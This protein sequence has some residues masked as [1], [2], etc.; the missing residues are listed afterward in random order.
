[1]MDDGWIEI[2]DQ[3]IDQTD[4]RSADQPIRLLIEID[5]LS[6]MFLCVWYMTTYML[7]TAC[8]LMMM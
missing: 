8:I 3:P 7:L 4:Q 1:M 2:R 6:K 5:K